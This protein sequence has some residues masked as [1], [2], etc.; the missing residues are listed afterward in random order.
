MGKHS[1]YASGALSWR[2]P[3]SS[4]ADR[5]VPPALPQNLCGDR[6]HHRQA[7]SHAIPGGCMRCTAIIN[8]LN[9]ARSC[10]W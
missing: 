3:N 8:R 7:Q 6:S 2:S 1:H 9:V 4:A 10:C 5:E